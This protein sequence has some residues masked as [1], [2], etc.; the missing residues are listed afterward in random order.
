MCVRVYFSCLLLKYIYYINIYQPFI[1]SR[2]FKPFI[3][4]LL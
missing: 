1:D 3:D 4:S 2:F